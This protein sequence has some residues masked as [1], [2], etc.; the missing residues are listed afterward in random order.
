MACTVK[1]AYRGCLFALSTLFGFGVSAEKPNY[2]ELQQGDTITVTLDQILPTQ[3]VMSYDLEYA[4]LQSYKSNEK[5]MF[6]KLC[7][8]N[9][10]GSVK[11]WGEKSNPTDL[12]S[13]T[14]A[15][16]LGSQTQD[17]A[18]V[19][20]GPK[21]G[22]LFLT[23]QHHTLSSFWDM[24]NGGTN[25]PVMLKVSHNLLDSGDDFWAEMSHDNTVW[26]FG[27]KGKKI[28]P[29]DLPEFIGSK[30]LKEDKFLALAFFL[31]G[32]SYDL[33][34][35]Q[36]NPNT[37][38]P[39][40]VVPYLAYQWS[41]ALREKMNV[42]NYNFNDRDDYATAL[43]EAA[44]VMTDLAADTLIGKS[45][46]TAIEMGQFQEVNSKA[47][48]ALITNKNS[49]WYLATEYRIQKKKKATPKKIQEEQE[50]QK[51]LEEKEKAE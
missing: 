49:N 11:D 9:G 6:N 40:A 3:A 10:G 19:V 14:C 21:E 28:S 34:Q 7:K 20:V 17:L 22:L 47:L 23:T 32:I 44:T 25:V 5:A 46:K 36:T 13:F 24:P 1:V 12:E 48:E 33:P 27:A 30:Q 43:T 50:K 26:L 18:K 39:Y 45:D 37:N 42:E 15:K 16:K 8:L 4:L 2:S 31:Q 35:K 41:L 51:A 38:E 29:S